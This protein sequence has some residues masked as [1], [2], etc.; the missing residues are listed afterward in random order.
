MRKG[1]PFNMHSA[2]RWAL[3]LQQTAHDSG[4]DNLH[5]YEYKTLKNGWA[6]CVTDYSTDC[7]AMVYTQTATHISAMTTIALKGEL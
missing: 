4:H 5:F 2:T 1:L 3:A 6:L 7:V